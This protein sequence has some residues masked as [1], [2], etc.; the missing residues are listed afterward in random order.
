MPCMIIMLQLASQLVFQVRSLPIHPFVL[1][2]QLTNVGLS[3]YQTFQSHV[4]LC[5][6]VASNSQIIAAFDWPLLLCTLGHVFLFSISLL[7]V[8][9]VKCVIQWF[10]S[11]SS[12]IFHHEGHENNIDYAFSVASRSIVYFQHIFSFILYIISIYVYTSIIVTI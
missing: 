8:I 10:C 1:Y 12:G 2:L 5:S 3:R 11:S 7:F 6:Y 4:Q 9:F